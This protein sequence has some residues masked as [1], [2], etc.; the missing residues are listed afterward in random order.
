MRLSLFADAG[1][2]WGP[3]RYYDGT[4]LLSKQKMDL[5]DLHLGRRFLAGLDIA[6]RAA[7][8]QYCAS[9]SSAGRRQDREKFQFTMGTMF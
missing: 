5:S 1:T 8:I 2:V 4:T 9:R 3:E 7:E 6:C